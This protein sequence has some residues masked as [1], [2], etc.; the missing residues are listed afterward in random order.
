VGVESAETPAAV[1]DEADLVV[2]GTDGF[3]RILEILAV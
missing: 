1:V 2:E 3:L